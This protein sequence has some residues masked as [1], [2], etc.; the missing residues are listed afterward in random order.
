MD[1]KHIA[2]SVFDS[3]SEYIQQKKLIFLLIFSIFLNYFFFLLKP[4]FYTLILIVAISLISSFFFFRDLL[5]ITLFGYF[6]PVF[7]VE[8]II[9]GQSIIIKL[10]D[11]FLISLFLIFLI[12]LIL[13]KERFKFK[14]SEILV[15]L[16]FFYAFVFVNVARTYLNYGIIGINMLMYFNWF[17]YFIFFIL[18]YKIEKDLIPELLKVVIILLFLILIIGGLSRYCQPLLSDLRMENIINFGLIFSTFQNLNTYAMFLAFLVPIVFFQ[19]LYLFETVTL[20]FLFVMNIWHTT[21]ISGLISFYLGILF[22]SFKRRKIYLIILVIIFSLFFSY[23]FRYPIREFSSTFNFVGNKLS[24]VFLA[25]NSS[26]FPE[27]KKPEN[28]PISKSSQFPEVKKP[29]NQPI[30]KITRFEESKIALILFTKKPIFGYGYNSFS[31]LN[32]KQ[33]LLYPHNWYLTM[34]VEGG[35]VQLILFFLMIFGIL[36]SLKIKDDQKEEEKN[37]ILGYKL[38]VFILLLG[39]LFGEYF[40]SQNFIAIFWIFSGIAF[41]INKFY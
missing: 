14:K 15:S 22:T 6:F 7:S 19:D 31:V 37:Y 10:N 5:L 41:K 35:M 8:Y 13:K 28:Q 39:L 2:L 33:K 27:V 11:I 12:N 20:S 29:E 24:K 32:S 26:Q 16:F 17:K 3:I 9:I 25:G 4:S 40:Y 18:F 36:R 23:N 1:Y 21:S 34:L 30:S 38:A